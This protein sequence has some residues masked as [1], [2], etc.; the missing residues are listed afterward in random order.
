MALSAIIVVCKGHTHAQTHTHTPD[1][2]RKMQRLMEEE[3][4]EGEDVKEEELL[5][6]LSWARLMWSPSV[7]GGVERCGD[8]LGQ[9]MT[10]TTDSLHF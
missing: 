1:K 5:P 6:P 4:E 9:S 8:G 3:W 7:C 10:V 2:D